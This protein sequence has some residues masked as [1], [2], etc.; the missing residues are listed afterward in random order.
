MG[1]SRDA[2]R[3]SV[4]MSVRLLRWISFLSPREFSRRAR[5]RRGR[6]TNAKERSLSWSVLALIRIR[7]RPSM[8]SVQ[9]VST[10]AS[11]SG[12]SSGA[13]LRQAVDRSGTAP[14][15]SRNKFG[16]NS[17]HLYRGEKTEKPHQ[18]NAICWF[19]TLLVVWW[20]GFATFG[21]SFLLSSAG[22]SHCRSCNKVNT[23]RC[24]PALSLRSLLVLRPKV[25]NTSSW[26]HP[27][28]VGLGKSW[29]KCSLPSSR[30]ALSTDGFRLCPF[31]L[32]LTSVRV[33]AFLDPLTFGF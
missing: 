9:R 2:V 33:H 15:G 30:K 18:Q 23:K 25:L 12:P 24:G 7:A 14:P 4:F 11:G 17:P 6:I 22:G 13:L 28:R 10:F 5:V 19:F 26:G 1:L 31:D 20:I 16:E 8:R 27:R 32:R 21:V 29:A 3:Q